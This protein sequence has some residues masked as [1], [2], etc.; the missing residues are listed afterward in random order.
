MWLVNLGTYFA[1][2]EHNR[3]VSKF[4]LKK[5]KTIGISKE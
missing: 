3:R 4:V 1:L 2:E 5:L